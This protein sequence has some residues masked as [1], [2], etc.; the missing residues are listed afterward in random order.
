MTKALDDNTENTRLDRLSN[1]R[2]EMAKLYRQARTGKIEP[3]AASRFVYM[4]KEI[5]CC[6][7]SEA[8]E[9]IEARLDEIITPKGAIRGPIEDRQ[10]VTAH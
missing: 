10:T 7:E 4:L 3:A 2:I 9:R 6:L 8:L 1:V 5:R